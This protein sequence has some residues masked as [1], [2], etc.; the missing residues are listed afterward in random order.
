MPLGQAQLLVIAVLLAIG[1]YVF[2]ELVDYSDAPL[3]LLAIPVGVG[4][5]SY[6]V[7]GG[8]GLGM[9]GG[10]LALGWWLSNG[11]PNGVVWVL[12]RAS[13]CLFVGAMLGWLVDSHERLH[14][15]LARH[16][17][18]S[19][20][21]IVTANF[22]GYFIEVNS[23]CTRLLGYT[24]DEFTA[25]PFTDFVHP[26]DLE[27]TLSAIAEQT[28]ANRPVLNFVNRYRC[29]D[30]SYRWL[31]WA[32]QPIPK[33]RELQAIARDI[34]ERKGLEDMVHDQVGRLE[35]AVRERTQELQERNEALDEAHRE[36]LHRLA[37]AVEYRDDSTHEH[38]RRIG[39]SAALLAA[40]VGLP[41]AKIEVIRNAAPLHDIGKI[42]VSDIVLLKP[43][44]LT[45][46]EFDHMK[47]HSEK[48]SAM[49]SGSQ[50]AVL[51]TAQQ[52]ALCH[53]E[54][55]DGSG[56]PNG[57]KGTEIPIS[58]RIVAL[59]DV[60]DALT[61]SRPYKDAWP[62]E[63]AVSE[64][65]SLSGLQFDPSIV[66][67]FMTLDPLELA[68]WIDPDN[69]VADPHAANLRVTNERVRF[70]ARTEQDKTPGWSPAFDSNGLAYGELSRAAA[71][72]DRPLV[73]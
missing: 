36:T 41:E 53:H 57:L 67:A 68:A 12:S 30:G 27:P 33:T 70:K 72:V 51:Q 20:D 23:S 2:S 69:P 55:W 62:I 47:Q 63:R 60:F 64:I 26:D 1:V 28:E 7:R 13:T 61:H 71:G 24:P 56:Y 29:K 10:L 73:N 59:A 50:S 66:D 9:L 8:L 11:Q 18:L 15:R 43:G 40:A 49:L 3:F 4:A 21:L 44:K 14:D 48:G 45:H 34:T 37:L 19:L 54:R 38:A 6:G 46:A 17:A 65:S 5:I 35:R 22:D 31:E 25:R 58:A 42:A 39:N 32:S 52:I 16:N